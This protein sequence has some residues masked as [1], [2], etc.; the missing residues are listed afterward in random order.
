MRALLIVLIGYW[1]VACNE[2]DSFDLSMTALE[3]GDVTA[4]FSGCGGSFRQGYLFCRYHEGAVPQNPIVIHVPKVDCKRDNCIEYRFFRK[5]GSVG[6]SAGIPAKQTRSEVPISAIT[7]AERQGMEHDGEYIVQVRVWFLDRH[8]YEHH[9][10]GEGLVR[11]FIVREGYVVMGCQSP[12][13]GW[14]EKIGDCSLEH[15][16]G[17][18]TALCGGC[19]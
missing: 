4:L 7:G 11:I 8:G 16:T 14:A 2:P 5:D 17:Y 12:E 3:G 15:S 19:E 13:R 1:M 18:R 6:Y 9:M 10:I